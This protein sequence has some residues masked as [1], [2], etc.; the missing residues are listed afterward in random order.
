MGKVWNNL[1]IND[2]F[3]SFKRKLVQS[4][5][6]PPAEHLNT[7]WLFL[8]FKTIVVDPHPRYALGWINL[9]LN[10][11]YAIGRFQNRI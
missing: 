3:I 4:H 7:D 5:T 2:S 11:S 1:L 6:I 9:Q 10:R 8:W